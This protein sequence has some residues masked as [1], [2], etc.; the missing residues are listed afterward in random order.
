[1]F[2][3]LTMYTNPSM[4]ERKG[5]RSPAQELATWKTGVVSRLG[6][7]HGYIDISSA[8]GNVTRNP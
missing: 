7:N 2:I 1:M 4:P 6:A 3:L 5:Q 8:I